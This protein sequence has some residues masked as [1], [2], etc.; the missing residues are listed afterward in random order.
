[1]CFT[2]LPRGYLAHAVYLGSTMPHQQHACMHDPPS[3]P[4]PTSKPCADAA[5]QCGGTP[6]ALL[7]AEPLLL[8]MGKRA[9]E[10]GPAGSG[11]I[12][13]VANNLTLAIQMAAVSEGLALGQALGIDPRTL[14]QVFNTSSA[15]CWSSEVY[16]PCPGVMEDVPAARAYTPGFTTQLCLKD[17]GLALQAAEE[18]GAATPMGKV[19]VEL[20]KQVGGWVAGGKRRRQDVRST[21]T[22]VQRWALPMAPGSGRGDGWQP[23]QPVLQF[24]SVIMLA[25]SCLAS[26]AWSPPL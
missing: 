20:Y 26:A 10:C 12:A 1:M 18:V 7:R 14:S 13:K 5:L 17:V 25:L 19:V 11:Q 2:D 21:G 16:N 6:S 4:G 23:Q 3:R 9:I 8:A 15:R 24:C 22:A